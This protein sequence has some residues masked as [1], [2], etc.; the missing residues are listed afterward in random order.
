MDI[1]T[2]V[3]AAICAAI[4]A[5]PAAA[6]TQVE[7][8]LAARMEA[9]ADKGLF[10]I[11][12]KPLTPEQKKAMQFL[13]AYMPL[14]DMADRPGE[15]HLA[16]VDCSLRARSEM[17]WGKS[18]PEREFMHFVLPVR[19]NNE[20]LDD[21]RAAFYAELRDRVRGLSM[22]D[23]ALEV[24]H[25]CHERVSYAPSD[26]RTNS[27]LASVRSATGR[28]GE[29]STLT[30]AALRAVGIPARQVYTPRWAHTDDNHAWVE[31]WVD[32]KWRFM[33]ACEPEAV[34]DLGW[35]NTSASRAMLVHTNVFGRYGGPEQVISRNNCYTE[36][37]VTSTY[38]PTAA[39]YVKTVD[40]TG[41]PV[42]ATVEFKVYNYA[43]FYTVAKVQS[44]ADGVASIVC[45][46]GDLL[47]WASDGDCFG[48]AKCTAGG[49]T[50][51]VV[52][53]K[54]PGFCGVSEI[55]IAPP[56]ESDNLPQVPAEKAAVNAARIA[57]EDS[58]RAAYVATFYSA[59]Q[60]AALAARTGL[61][62]AAVADVMAK[63]RGNH[64]TV[65][66]FL[67]SAKDK[68]KALRLLRELTAKDLG[69]ITPEVLRDQME[70][71]APPTDTT[72]YYSSLLNPRVKTEQLT[73]YKAFFSASLPAGFAERFRREP[74]Q[75]AAWCRDSIAVDGE[76][77]PKAYPM[78]AESVWK[79]RKAD[80]SSRDIFFVAAA[81]AMGITARL[82]PVDG[83]PQYSI[84]GGVWTDAEMQA[85]AQE[86]APKG[87]LSATYSPARPGD[88]PKYYTHFSISKITDG[89][90]S[91]L[92]Y[93][94]DAT[95]Q[96]LLSD[97]GSEVDAGQYLTVSGTRLANGG[98]LARLSFCTVAPGETATQQLVLR[99]SA[100]QVQ[101]IG[102][103]NAEN[104]YTDEKEGEKTIL[105][106]T[107]RGYYA[108]GLI[109]PNH[110][111]STHAL[112]DLA[113]AAGELERWGRSIILLFASEEDAARFRNKADF[114]ALPA[115]VRF[116]VDK[117]G[118]VRAELQREMKIRAEL[119]TFAIADTFNRVV[120]ISEGYTIGLGQKLAEVISKL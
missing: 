81:R 80:T 70:N 120:F 114:A 6:G 42:P 110:E 13:Y 7:K 55:D 5:A 41:K 27:P 115:N 24:N 98:V 113:A 20:A 58:M 8:D 51:T 15:Y 71:T 60:S 33:G 50:A 85:A 4:S 40:S 78:S 117:G 46:K 97:E 45:G 10:S 88:N 83:T 118:A 56:A 38:A 47:A 92:N 104:T 86:S 25:W 21:S 22:Y 67:M 112:N 16:N 28:C 77:N 18:V 68:P 73:T 100:D 57:M 76:W 3:A 79:L 91:L 53:D 69:D 19:V 116:G 61:D 11:F 2:S 106:T 119:P 66:G 64:E 35:F 93:P 109:A 43:E 75:W 1:R 49:D 103:L 32:G 14:P 65:A 74:R 99:R 102:V 31:A 17:P 84:G 48:F 108:I 44:G 105:S 87:R 29:E 54:G 23:A 111:P 39:A 59:T 96:S 30:V 9:T 12:G 94:E 89:S 95:W 107:G 36:I 82:D 26:A 72:L 63:A 62:S 101:V 34:L 90:P 37:A 52:V